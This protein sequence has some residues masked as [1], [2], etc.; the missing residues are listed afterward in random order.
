MK[1]QAEVSAKIYL[2]DLVGQI[3]KADPKILTIDEKNPNYMSKK[4]IKSLAAMI[5]KYGWLYP[6]I[7]DT[8]GRIIDG[9][10]RLQAALLLNQHPPV[11][12]VD[13]AVT[14]TDKKFLRQWLNKFRGEHDV[15]MDIS[16]LEYLFAD[17]TGAVLMEDYMDF[18]E[19]N[20]DDMKKLLD[21]PV[22]EDDKFLAETPLVDKKKRIILFYTAHDYPAVRKKLD[23][24]MAKYEMIDEGQAIKLLLDESV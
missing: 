7:A 23:D 22:A 16:E 8:E 21:T 2:K 4:K 13:T 15:Q 10:Q 19:S 9:H 12:V 11:L 18:R 5:E 24:L 14:D 17:E 3:V 20:I 6:I 1:P